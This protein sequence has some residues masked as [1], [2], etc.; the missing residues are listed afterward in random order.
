MKE[1]KINLKAYQTKE[2]EDLLGKELSALKND[3]LVYPEIKKLNLTNREAETFI[4]SLIDFK[5]DV[6]YCASCPG[7]D[8]C[9]KSHPHFRLKLEKDGAFLNRHY[10]PCEKMVSL[11]SFHSRYIRCSFPEEWRDE[12][13]RDIEQSKSA[14]TNALMAMAQAVKGSGQWIY[15]NGNA[16]SGRS[17]MLACLANYV[18]KE[19]GKGAFVDTAELLAEMKELSIKNR[20]AFESLLK[21]LSNASILVFDDLGNEYKTEYV[22]TTVLYPLISA[23]DKA[24][25]I[26]CFA[27]DFPMKEFISMYRSKIGDE[28]ASQLEALLKRRCKKEFDVTGVNV[29]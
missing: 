2:T 3:E 26:T 17:Y 19:Q 29:H 23:R 20:D 7:L 1:I 27:S 13:L 16:G 24:G 25:L 14:R 21:E 12:N 6:H 22:Y 4:A 10:D 9:A 11:V 5:E 15:L 28:R 18:T 8:R